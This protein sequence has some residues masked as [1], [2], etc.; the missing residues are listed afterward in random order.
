MLL[1]TVIFLPLAGALVAALLPAGEPQQHRGWALFVS[2]ATFAVS[3]GLWAGFDASMA[4]PEFQFEVNLPW[5]PSAG[6]GFHVGLDGVAL[7]RPLPRLLQV[8]GRHRTRRRGVGGTLGWRSVGRI[9]PDR[10][11][12]HA[13]RTSD[14]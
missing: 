11:I 9:H 4:A 12:C 6:I 5:V 14:R 8:H 7:L 2:A 1:A 13:W 10:A 3:L